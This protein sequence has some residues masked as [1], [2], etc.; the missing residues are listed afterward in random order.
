MTDDEEATARDEKRLAI[1]EA[2]LQDFIELLDRE[3]EVQ[4]RVEKAVG[5]DIDGLFSG[6]GEF[7]AQANLV[8]QGYQAML[9]D[10]SEWHAMAYAHREVSRTK[11]ENEIELAIQGLDPSQA[12]M[13]PLDKADLVSGLAQ[14]GV[15]FGR[16]GWKGYRAWNSGE[17]ALPWA[18][19]AGGAAVD[20]AEAVTSTTRV[21]DGAT[22]AMVG[23]VGA[24]DEVAGRAAGPRR[25]R[26]DRDRHPAA[27]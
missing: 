15:L 10:T 17:L 8:F 3:D 22:P 12:S 25:R 14:L 21:A 11:E 26:G 5:D 20:T 19:R 18:T 2:Y 4:N 1:D 16:A 24:S 6:I 27:W 9:L 7:E 23:S 13:S